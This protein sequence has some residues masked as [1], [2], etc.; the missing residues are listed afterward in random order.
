MISTN[1]DRYINQHT[2][3][4]LQPYNFFTLFHSHHL[5]PETHYHQPVRSSHTS[6][7]IATS[8]PTSKMSTLINLETPLQPINQHDPTRQTTSPLR[9]AGH[10]GQRKRFA[11][12]TPGREFVSSQGGYDLLWAC[13]QSRTSAFL[14]IR[15]LISADS[16]SIVTFYKLI[17][18][19]PSTTMTTT[20]TSSH[21]TIT[22]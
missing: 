10:D 2:C 17:L 5:F 12:L 1:A 22:I 9:S 6:L 19:F 14:L 20:T 21:E 16:P 8:S 18:P 7:S 11:R 4:S 3:T 15:Y 13:R